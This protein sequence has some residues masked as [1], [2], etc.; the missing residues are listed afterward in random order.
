MIGVT[1]EPIRI[2]DQPINVQEVID[3]VMAPSSGAV[4]LFIGTVRSQ[5]ASRDVIQLE[6]EAYE[7]M[8][9][10][11]MEKISA[12]IIKKWPVDK[13]SMVHRT[14]TLKV[15]EI[16]VVIAVSTPH[17]EEAF[18]AT[19]YAIDTLKKTVPIWKKEVFNGGE[20]WVSAHP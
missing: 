7:S 3:S 4:N 8:A 9:I 1:E 18:H 12:A 15:G 5:T 11:E 17:R 16:A 6:F 14:G 10:K 19:K 20:I 13:V 2:T